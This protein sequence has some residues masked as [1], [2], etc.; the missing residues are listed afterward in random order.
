M[1]M[2]A[3]LKV[4]GGGAVF[5]VQLGTLAKIINDK[6]LTTHGHLKNVFYYMEFS[7]LHCCSYC[8]RKRKFL[9]FVISNGIK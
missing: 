4:G 9:F 1:N 6:S 2:F 3:F 7:N 8:K 5:T